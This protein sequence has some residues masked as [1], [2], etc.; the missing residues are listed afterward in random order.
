MLCVG[1]RGT[2]S[3]T[4][5]RAS[6]TPA[7]IAGVLS[8]TSMAEDAAVPGWNFHGNYYEYI[9]LVGEE[10]VNILVGGLMVGG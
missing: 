5:R 6:T 4:L 7:G 1:L 10:G 3:N 9:C 2:V 8:D